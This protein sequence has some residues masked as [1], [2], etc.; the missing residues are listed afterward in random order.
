MTKFFFHIDLCGTETRDDTGQMLV[1]TASALQTAMRLAWKE[2]AREVAQGKLCLG[3]SVIV[4]DEKTGE[5]LVVP[6]RDTIKL[7]GITAPLST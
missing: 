6:F 2:M 4:E 3:C 5:R 7:T 1:D